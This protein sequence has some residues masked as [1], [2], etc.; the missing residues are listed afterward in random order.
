MHPSFDLLNRTFDRIFVVTLPRALERQARVTSRLTGLD[1][2]FFHGFDRQQ[3]DLDR[4]ARE[5]VYAPERARRVD[6]HGRALGAGQVGCSLSHRKLYEQ[7]IENGW[8]RVLVLEDDVVA[9]DDDLPQLT[10]A[11]SQ[12]PE[13]WDV[14]YLGYTNFETV[15][16][17]DRVKQASYVVLS[18]LRLM[19]WR[20]REILRFH[21]RP[22]SPNLRCA[23]L[24]HCTHAYAFTLAGAKKLLAAQTPV[25]FPADQLLVHLV[26]RGE[27][28]AFVTEPKFFD[29]EAP[30]G[31][32][33]SFVAA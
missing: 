14:L 3:L 10:A 25:A 7:A 2:R 11:L 26:L 23:G 12:L 19:K 32:V 15:T 16:R 6:R 29:Q 24:H 9:R 5:G 8:S 27:I 28:R 13:A 22:F 21:P 1:Y 31:G 4:L 30:P 20:P 33:G 17:R 18:A